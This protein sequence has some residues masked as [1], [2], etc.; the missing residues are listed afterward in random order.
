MIR[1]VEQIDHF[2]SEVPPRGYMTFQQRYLVYSAYWSKE[3]VELNGEVVTK[4]G[5]IF[6][7]TGNEADVTLYANATGLMWEHAEVRATGVHGCGSLLYVADFCLGGVAIQ[8]F[9]AL[10]VFA[11]HRF[12][13]QSMPFEE[14][15][16]KY[17][18]Y[19]SS[20]QALADYA[21]LI[22]ELKRRYHCES[23]PVIA[24]GGSYGGMLAS[25]LRIKYP[26]IV[27]GAISASAPIWSFLAL[28]PPVDPNAFAD[29]ATA[30]AT[31]A[32]GCADACADNVR[33]SWAYLSDLS[34]D[35]AGRKYL[36]ETFHLC[37]PLESEADVATLA[38][39]IQ[40][41]S[42]CSLMS[43]MP[44]SGSHVSWIWVLQ[45][46]WYY[47]AMGDFPYPS[48]YILMGNG[49]LPAFPVC[50][51]CESLADPKLQGDAQAL[52]P[53]L[54]AAVGVYYN[55]TGSVTC[56]D[57]TG[58]VNEETEY[59]E[60]MW[61]YQYCTELLMPSSTNGVTDMF[62]DQPWSTEAMVQWC[63]DEFGVTPRLDWAAIEYGGKKL[64][65]A[66]NIVFSNGVLDPWTGSGV[67]KVNG[68]FNRLAGMHTYSGVADSPWQLPLSNVQTS[69]ATNRLCDG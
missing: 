53:A 16:Q 39:W 17:K 60:Y 43:E 32:G 2:S 36:A 57:F 13:G 28:D 64:Q 20:E 40:V 12:Y 15:S 6:F 8:E 38:Y 59:D 26:H 52:L 18:S 44:S 11:E 35:A 27:D 7:Y 49:V 45:T 33:A 63:Q 10:I 30:D 69:T 4:R 5:P 37:D 68:S 66:S 54:A 9:G 48:S 56:Y 25:W 22:F 46:A 50:V 51:A 67:T 14:D 58:S 55:N 23:S 34:A 65:Y 29:I 47:M 61:N 62:W 41:G 19:L 21:T 1:W 31:A 24:F 3:Q 42:Q